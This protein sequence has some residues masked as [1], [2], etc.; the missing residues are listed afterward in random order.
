M[1][2]EPAPRPR[3]PRAPAPPPPLGDRRR[4][5]VVGALAGAA[6]AC[7]GWRFHAVEVADAAPRRFEAWQQDGGI[8]SELAHRGD[9][10]CRGGEILARS[11]RVRSVFADVPNIEDPTGFVIEVGQVLA[12]TGNERR[13]LVERLRAPGRGFAWVRRG[14]TESQAVRL[15]GLGL[16]GLGFRDEMRR[17]YPGGC[18]AAHVTGLVDIDGRPLSGVEA[19]FDDL[20]SGVDG[21]REVARDGAGQPIVLADGI[22]VPPLDG[23]T[24]RLT[25]ER[26]VQ[27]ACEDALDSV[28]AEFRPRG[29]M[30]VALEPTTGAI[31]GMASRPGY[32]PADP[33]SA[34][35]DAWRNR[36][37]ADLY[38]PGSTFKP[39]I[40]VAALDA[41]VVHPADVIDC[42]GGVWRYRGR[43]L[44]D[45]H[46][47]GRLA[48]RDV[49]V[50]SSNIGMA[51][52]GLALGPERAQAALAGLGFDRP[53]GMGLGG[54][55]AGRITP[56]NRWSYYTTTSVAM[57]HELALTPLQLC[58]AFAALANGG[59]RMRPYIL[60]EVR[61][62]AGRTVAR[63]R[64][65][66]A[67]RICSVEAAR[68]MTDILCGVVE[69]EHGT[70][71]RAH[72]DGVRV[73][74]KTGTA[75]HERGADRG[76]YVSS[77]VAYAPAEQPLI[78][79]LVMVDR[80]QGSYYGGTVAAPAV[81]QILL[82]SLPVL[83][84]RARAEAGNAC[85]SSSPSPVP[86]SG[87]RP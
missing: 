5:A 78:C 50:R 61:D 45:A 46:P 38:P 28:M 56:P 79:V 21:F 71:R 67:S 35:A 54:E 31:L 77:F 24:I 33:G 83:E 48:F 17:V 15:E 69:D 49:I 75:Q 1:S 9:I 26:T 87:G 36:T 44:H 47:H 12:L 59:V 39:L 66:V 42:H 86:E 11:V 4:S 80:P 76:T 23:E 8:V 60:E 52:V 10:L 51:Q 19:A 65:Q 85:A 29:A 2:D 81:R 14:P 73:A 58:Q 7:M 27:A 68:I 53:T 64:P 55:R 57:G 74:G 34:P 82:R 43:T 70:G 3:A 84:A 37:I 22:E 13:D 18:L 20:L 40:G 41:G 62:A 32:D 25:I 63:Q 72:I 6:I 16:P 30:A